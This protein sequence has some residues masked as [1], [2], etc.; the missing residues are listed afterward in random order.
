MN[1][2]SVKTWVAQPM[3]GCPGKNSK[4]EWKEIDDRKCVGMIRR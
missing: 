3:R 1:G 2:S 4:G